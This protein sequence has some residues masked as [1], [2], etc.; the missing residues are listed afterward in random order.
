MSDNS[1][2][3][4]LPCNGGVQCRDDGVSHLVNRALMV[5]EN[6]RGRARRYLKD[7]LAL[8]RSQVEE[9]NADEP[10]VNGLFRAGGLARWQVS[11]TVTYIDSHLDS[12]LD[13]KALAE[14]VSLSKSHFSRA[15]RRSFGI[16]PMTYV[17]LRRIERAKGLMTSTNQQLTEIAI[18][19]G[20][21]DQSHFN[22]CFRRAIGESPGRWR[23]INV[24]IESRTFKQQRVPRAD[25]DA[26]Q[27]RSA[28][29]P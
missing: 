28:A 13:I 8:L 27:L 24:R 3:A 4:V 15:F 9:P 26:G 16:S 6:D 1:E 21:A 17:K 5:L 7:A 14:L 10:P 18:N 29:R 22:R 23:R 25:G 2:L 20:F 12:G 19:C 11:R